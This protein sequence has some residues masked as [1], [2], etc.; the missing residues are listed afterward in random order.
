MKIAILGHSGSGKSTLA[1]QLALIYKIPLLFLDTIQF[2]SDWK[3]RD[4]EESKKLVAEFMKQDSWVID[5]NY[6]KFFQTERLLAADKIIYMDFP[7]R[8]C[9]YQ[10][11]KRYFEFKNQS[12]DSISNGCIEKIDFEFIWW[13]L[14]EGRTK[15]RRDHYKQMI[16]DYKDKSIVLKNKKQVDAFLSELH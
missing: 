12:R 16:L 8:V 14:H 13:I 9:L 6:T 10:A 11:L 5:G 4:L 2:E 3:E 15:S 7:R 1:K